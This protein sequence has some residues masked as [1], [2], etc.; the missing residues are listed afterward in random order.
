M[1]LMM[2]WILWASPI[3]GAK[4]T[5]VYSAALRSGHPGNHLRSLPNPQVI[6][7]WLRWRSGDNRKQHQNGS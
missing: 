4:Q 6:V 7:R 5:K 3:F 2:F 1:Y